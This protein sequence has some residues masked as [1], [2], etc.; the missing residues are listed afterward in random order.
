M[1]SAGNP[2]QP[3][4]PF[5]VHKLFKP[6]PNSTAV[7]SNPPFPLPMAYPGPPPGPF[8]YPPQTAAFHQHSPHPFH[9]YGQDPLA[10]VYAQ[11]S[12]PAMPFGAPMA[13][14]SQCP[15]PNSGARLMA[16]LGTP[17][18]A[19]LETAVSMPPNPSSQTSSSP[20]NFHGLPTVPSAP[21]MISTGLPQ[22]SPGKINKLPHGRFISPG[23]RFVYDV[24]VKGSSSPPQLEVTPITKYTSDPGL[25]FGR[26]IAVNRSYIC[27]GLR[28]GSIRV[29][30]I[31]TALRSLLRGHAQRV[32]DMAFFA[33]DVHLLASASVDGKIFVWKISEGPDKQDKPEIAGKVLVA[34]QIVSDD[35]T[36]HPL[37]CWHCHKQ[38]IL[39]VGVGNRLLKIDMTK[40]GK[41]ETVSG[42]EEPLK[43]HVD[44][45]IDGVQLIGRHDQEITDLSMCQW[46]MTRLVSAS[47]DGT[48]KIWD[49]RKSTPLVTLRPHDGQP[50]NCV[51]FLTAPHRP[52]H[53]LLI[54]AGS[55]NREVKLWASANQEGWLLPS[56]C[57]SWQCMQTLELISS[58]ESDV[59]NAFFNQVVVLPQANL[60]LLANAKKNVIYAIHVNYGENP[61]TTRMDYISEFSVKMPILSITATSDSYA[62]IMQMIQVYCVQTQAIQQ[63]A[64]D[65]SLC[66]PPPQENVKLEIESDLSGA[67]AAPDIITSNPEVNEES[68]VSQISPGDSTFFESAD[69][70]SENR[71]SAPPISDLEAEICQ[72]AE[73]DGGLEGGVLNLADLSLEESKPE[74][75]DTDLIPN[76]PTFTHLVT[77]SEILSRAVSSTE[78]SIAPDLTGAEIKIPVVGPSPVTETEE[79]EVK[80]FQEEPESQRGTH[81]VV[82]DSTLSIE[83]SSQN[84]G[85]GAPEV[86]VSS[87][88]VE[89][90]YFLVKDVSKDLAGDDSETVS[91]CV[92]SAVVSESAVAVMVEKSS[93]IS[94][95]KK[96]KAKQFEVSV[97]HA[98]TVSP[99]DTGSIN[100]TEAHSNFAD[101]GLS[102]ALASMQAMLNKV[103]T[104]QKDMQNQ[105]NAA[106]SLP[107]T[108]EGK[109][110]EVALGRCIE[111]AIKANNDVLWARFQEETA[112]RE[113]LEKERM[114]QMTNL[115]SNVLNKD[116]PAIIEKAIKKEN[117]SLGPSLSRVITPALEKA[118]SSAIV[119]SFQ[120]GV[121]DKAVNQLE[122][123]VNSKLEVTV[124]RQIQAQF[125][126][127]AK[128]YLQDGIR[129]CLEGSII[130][131]FELACKGMFDQ[132]DAGFHKGMA[133]HTTAVQQQLES[134]HT[135][136]ALSL[137]DAINSALAVTQTLSSEVADGQRKL[138][139]LAAAANPKPL[140]SRAGQ[141][142]NGTLRDLV[143]EVPVDP[144]KELARL[145]S[146]RK[147]DEAFTAALQRSDVSIVSWL[148]S[149]VD[150]T[151]LCSVSPLPLSQGVLLSLL[152]QLACDLG[153]DTTQKLAWMTQVAVAVDPNDP[154]IKLHVRPI[155][156]QVYQ[157]LLHQ[158]SL[159]TTTAADSNSIR[160]MLHVIHSVLSGL[161]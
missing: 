124:A 25:V 110:V 95:R 55:L 18:Q 8:S 100:E 93:S 64:L 120:K 114:Q 28:Q 33:E 53:I 139:S 125:Q 101:S 49:D 7:S 46:M 24:D 79:V 39:V 159:P 88:S 16:L 21:P 151:M 74:Q 106:V 29:L 63:Y 58:S 136:L 84:L 102:N 144:T 36:F 48:V 66:L 14:P 73:S 113:K 76:L 97:S 80:A 1:A 40:V 9:H 99:L 27:Y 38:E 59:Q 134:A 126:T 3:S 107:V 127:S 83:S 142:A 31:N 157:I 147:F 148:C 123:S 87:E 5:D 161:K 43:C 130:P 146:E 62:D 133:E 117:S 129:S 44:K 37:V 108:K 45:L 41:A 90:D 70:K 81:T 78:C 82:V 57:E 160:L 30:N 154:M 132:I 22:T 42:E 15:P 20:V 71:P 152:Q 50:V 119:D 137:R 94:K 92:A 149:Q 140:E 138:L 26:Q 11:Q 116:L 19:P 77:P 103:M 56:D 68:S 128:Q 141:Q 91:E 54:T 158:R 122:K 32:T 118:I 10:N 2:N 109:R 47:K 104:I 52:D 35:V 85:E 112:K 17:A 6:P 156:D 131:S 61:L 150:L 96:Q 115:V 4:A 153:K 98:T 111:K 34:I 121:G 69:L 72:A 51:S 13:N 65:L 135:P 155:F 67:F 75:S 86:N 105:M 12:R 143:A 145:I 60:I 89:Q 23:D